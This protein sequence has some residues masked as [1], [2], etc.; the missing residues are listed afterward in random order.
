MIDGKLGAYNIK[1][2][3]LPIDSNAEPIFHNPRPIPSAWKEKIEQQLRNYI[4]TDVAEIIDNSDWGTPIVPILKPDESIRP[5]GD[6]KV[7]LNKYLLDFKY[8][9]PRIE[10]MFT[11]LQGGVIFTKLDMSNAHNQLILDDESQKLCTLSTHIGTLK[12]KRSPFCVKP[13]AA[14][15]Q[16]TMEDLLREFTNVVVFQ[17]D[18]TVTG[19]NVNEH[20]ITLKLVEGED[21]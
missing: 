4:S 9:L 5:C 21:T 11:A 12:M 3:S 10:E 19:R 6:Y 18:I 17:D 14:I 20:L 13:A 16:K 7:T 2:I 1:K 8:P 15:F